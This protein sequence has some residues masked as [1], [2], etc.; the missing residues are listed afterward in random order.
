M[1]NSFIAAGG[2]V[3]TVDARPD[4]TIREFK[5]KILETFFDDKLSRKVASVKLAV[6]EKPLLDNS[7]TLADSGISQAVAVLAVFSKKTV[8]CLCAEDAPL[9]L[10]VWDRLVLL[11][12][13]DGT[14]EIPSRAFYACQCVAGVTI[15]SL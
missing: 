14:T 10:N 7:V 6:A 9:D 12:I 3:T 11:N 15:S 1:M 2:E 5:H 4:A 8:E 13:P